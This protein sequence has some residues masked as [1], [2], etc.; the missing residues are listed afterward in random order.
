MSDINYTIN[1]FVSKG[2]FSQQYIAAGNTTD[3]SSAGVL[4]VTLEPG[5]GTQ[6][7]STASATTLGYCMARNLAEDTAG[8]AVVTFGRLSGTTLLETVRLRPGDAAWLRLAPGDYAARGVAGNPTLLL[9]ILE[10]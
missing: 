7:I 5:T 8:T 10:D 1:A 3:M 6:A 4:A 2:K 9:E